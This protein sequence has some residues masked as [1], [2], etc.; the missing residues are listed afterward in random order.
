M[1]GAVLETHKEE[2]KAFDTS[3]TVVRFT[4]NQPIP[5]RLVLKLVKARMAEIQAVVRNEPS[6]AHVPGLRRRG[7]GPCGPRGSRLRSGEVATEGLAR[8]VEE[9]ML[10]GL[11]HSIT[12][13]WIED[14]APGV[15]QDHRR[16]L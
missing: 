3:N 11:E 2:L 4:P 6:P 12:G 9:L 16:K 5:R 8:T 14:D 1:Y 10:S 15:E 13:H 7:R